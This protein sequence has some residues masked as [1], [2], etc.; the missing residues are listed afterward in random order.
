MRLASSENSAIHIQP[1]DEAEARCSQLACAGS[2]CPV[3]AQF[4]G[5]GRGFGN[6]TLRRLSMTIAKP[7][8][9]GHYKS[10]LRER[11]RYCRSLHHHRGR[12]PGGERF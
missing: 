8:R 2:P 3:I 1:A 9:Y 5:P 6:P 10:G 12:D 7:A 11:L 4:L